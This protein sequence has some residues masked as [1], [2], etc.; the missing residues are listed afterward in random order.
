[1]TRTQLCEGLRQGAWTFVCSGTFP[2]C[3]CANQCIRAHTYTHTHAHLYVQTHIYVRC[4]S[5]HISAC[6]HM[7]TRTR[8][9]RHTRMPARTRTYACRR[10]CACVCPRITTRAHI[11][12]YTQTQDTCTRRHTQLRPS[13]GSCG[14]L[15]LNTAERYVPLSAHWS[16]CK[17]KLSTKSGLS[18][19][20]CTQRPSEGRRKGSWTR[21]T[22]S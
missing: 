7:H 19:G 6:T 16:L 14:Q 4:A 2:T 13:V 5:L 9:H 15:S 21:Q 18:F 22:E 10:V 17:N 20:I 1:M 11:C 3:A 8:A 12:T